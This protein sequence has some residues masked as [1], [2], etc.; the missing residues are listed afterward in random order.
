M[1]A[2]HDVLTHRVVEYRG[3]SN[4]TI[5]RPAIDLAERATTTRLPLVLAALA[6]PG[7]TLTWGMF[8]GAGFVSGVPLAIAAIATGLS[9]RR[10][11]GRE[12][13]TSIAIAIGAVALLFVAVCMATGGD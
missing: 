11:A 10:L 2:G 1:S 12:R 7:V 9:R 5:T 13:A 3:M 8:E 6:V 4:Q